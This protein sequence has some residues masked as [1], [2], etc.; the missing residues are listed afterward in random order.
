MAAL[1]LT[2]QQVADTVGVSRATVNGVKLGRT[3]HI[4][5]TTLKLIADALGLT[6]RDLFTEPHKTKTLPIKQPLL[7][8]EKRAA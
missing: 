2:D 5:I 1:R 3:K 4:S 7:F 6:W 8:E